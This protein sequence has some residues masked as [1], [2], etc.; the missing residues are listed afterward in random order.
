M[1]QKY[2]RITGE[3][4]CKCENKREGIH[5][6]KVNMK[7]AFRKLFTDHA[8]YTVFVLKGIIDKNDSVTV[9]LNRLLDNQKDIGD[10]LK[11]IIGEE[12]GNRVTD[13]LKEHIRLAG[14]VIKSISAKERSKLLNEKIAVLLDNGDEFSRF[15]SSLSP[16]K[17]P[18]R[19][20]IDMFERHN[21]FVKDMAIA[22]RNKDYLEEQKL[23][24]AYY[25]EILEMSDAIVNAL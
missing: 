10:Q 21:S 23:Y 18:E 2:C 13:L 4:H 11:P 12:N 6:M 17:L 20:M 14:E 3:K 19:E 22:R 15:L 24:D 7:E 5:I 25:N 1:E 9:F 16:D 8:C